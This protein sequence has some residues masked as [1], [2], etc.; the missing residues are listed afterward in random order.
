MRVRRTAELDWE[1]PRSR[2]RGAVAY[3]AGRWAFAL[4]LAGL[5]YA[6]FPV[7]GGVSVPMLE[8]GEVAQEAVLA[9]FD[10]AVRRSPEELRSEAEALAASVPSVYD[11]RPAALDSVLA[12]LDSLFTGL[13]EVVSGSAAGAAQVVGVRLTPE[14]IAYLAPAARRQAFQRSLRSLFV[15]SLRRGVAAAGTLET[16]RMREIVVRRDG[17][18]GFARRDTLWTYDQFLQ[19][20]VAVHP[21]PGSAL[22]DQLYLKLVNRLFRPSLVYNAVETEARR[23]EL[24]ASVD[25]VKYVVR[26]QEAIVRANDLVTPAVRERLLALRAELLRRGGSGV[27]PAAALGQVLANGLLLAIVWLLLALYRRDIYDRLRRV[28]TL[29][30]IFAVVIVASAINRAHLASVPELIPVPFAAI[31]TSVLFGGRLAMIVGAVLALLIAMQA[32]FGTVHAVLVATVAGVASAISVRGIRHRHALL[33]AVLYVVA[34]LLVAD[35]S[36]VLRS[37]RPVVEAGA[38]IPWGVAN[39]FVS[40]ALAFY[41]LPV[42]ERMAQVTTDLTL[43]E[44][45]D[46][47]RPLL[48]R[49]ATEAPGTYAHSVAMANLCEATCNALGANGLLARVGCYYHDIGKLKKPQYFVENQMQGANPHDKLKPEVSAAIIRNHV[50]DGLALA[51]EYGLPDVVKAFIPEHHGTM[52]IAYFLDRA[53]ARGGDDELDLAEYRYPGPRPRSVETAVAMLADGVEAAL[54]VLEDPT[55]QQIK[56]AIAHLIRQRVEA[57]QLDEAPITMA[58]LAGIEE[59]FVRFYAG[60]RHA[61]IDYPAAGGGIT[62]DWQAASEV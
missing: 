42:F 8:V 40:A 22:A 37:G 33:V 7:A 51:E 21:D 61:R 5:T 43:L 29:A 9:P 14:E 39:A 34:A 59:E 16:E 24:R 20:R 53:R 45:S 31:L 32:V 54:R 58:Q 48:R 49:L 3:H 1:L 56:D 47:N 30:L 19:S 52:E 36:L 2:G 44:L 25:S 10:F 12:D 35:L 17:L 62:A 27:R 38:G 57:R 55:E 60:V 11:F 15:R 6:V 46:P 28:A 23:E 41:V 50:R 18:E 26:A 4:G 13:A